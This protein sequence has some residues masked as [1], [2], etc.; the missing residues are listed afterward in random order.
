M[1]RSVVS[2]V[3]VDPDLFAGV[4]ERLRF[5][6]RA[7]VVVRTRALARGGWRGPGRL[8]PRNLG[9]LIVS[10]LV[11]REL[12]LFNA[13]AIELIG[14]GDLLAPLAMLPASVSRTSR[15]RVLAP[16]EVAVLDQPAMARLANLPGVVP[17]L[18][19]RAIGRSH[20][21]ETQLALT[22]IHPLS[23]RLLVLFW[24]LADRWGT[25]VNGEVHLEIPLSHQ[26][27]A[28]LS[29][30]QRPKVT[31]ALGALSRRGLVSRSG[32]GEGWVLSGPPPSPGD[33]PRSTTL[34][35]NGDKSSVSPVA[36]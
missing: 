14:A 24:N 29:S 19:R 5:G 28:D 6:L 16:T 10:G 18:V 15:W 22:R 35:A 4:P 26:V 33:A 2:L 23:T 12:G 31:A 20:A 34:S 17:E 30:A 27:L 32:P 7:K 9:L 21:V 8:A 3:D 1:K 11:L 13:T 25:R 36:R